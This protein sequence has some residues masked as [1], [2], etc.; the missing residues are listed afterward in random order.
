[1]QFICLG[2]ELLFLFQ[3]VEGEIE[4]DGT[5]TTVAVKILNQNASLEDKARFLDEALIYRDS[6]HENI[7]GF[8]ASCLQEDPW[9]LIFELCP[10][11][12]KVIINQNIPYKG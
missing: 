9:I 5:T 6:S 2:C 12:S 7:L 1:M 8:V 10:M 4:D 3:V 11:V